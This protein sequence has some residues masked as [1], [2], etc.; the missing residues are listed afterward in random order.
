M[1]SFVVRGGDPR[2]LRMVRR[3]RV[4]LEASS[5]GGVETLVSL[6]FNTSHARLT[7]SQRTEA[8]KRWAPAVCT[9]TRTGG[10]SWPRSRAVSAAAQ[11][12]GNSSEK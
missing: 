1:W 4:A 7:E 10:S 3:L 8:G 11:R 12:A 2:A 9:F 5:L 6:P